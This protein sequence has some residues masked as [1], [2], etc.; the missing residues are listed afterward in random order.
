MIL[1]DILPTYLRLAMFCGVLSATGPR[2]CAQSAWESDDELPVGGVELSLPTNNDALFYGDGQAFYQYTYRKMQPG[3]AEAWEGGKYGFV[4]NYRRLRDG[5]VYQR[6]HEGIDIRSVDRSSEA[7]EP[8]DRVLAIADG[9]VVYTNRIARH[10]SYG[11][12]VVVEHWWEGAPFYSLYAHL[13][14]INVEAGQDVECGADLGLLGYTGVGIDRRRAHL[15]LEVGLMLSRAFDQWYES[16]PGLTVANR[17][18]M[19]NGVNLAG[20]DVAALFLQARGRP[21]FSIKHFLANEKPYYAVVAPSQGIPDMLWRYPWL[22][23]Q[24]EGWDPMYGPVS[25]LGASWRI[26]F[27]RSGFPLR[28]EAIIDPVGEAV[29]EVLQS[30]PIP[31]DY[32]TSGRLRGTGAG[33]ELTLAGQRYIDLLL[34]PSPELRGD[35]E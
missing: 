1:A 30:S 16:V 15:H 4:R 17:H 28:F 22:S 21:D 2:L 31:F 19:Y 25:D 24:L 6:F 23:P 8:R 11:Q 27:T 26:V 18:G 10:S 12:Y 3:V 14:R 32:L 34:R 33:V 9:I 13:N 7:A 20:M 5:A 29:V 35:L